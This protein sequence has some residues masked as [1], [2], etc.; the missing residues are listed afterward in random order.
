MEKPEPIILEPALDFFE[1]I[2]YIEEKYKIRV[3]DYLGHMSNEPFLKTK[4]KFN[5]ETWYRASPKDYTPFQKEASVYFNV[6]KQEFDKLEY[7]NYWHWLKDN[8]FDL[9]SNG[10]IEIWGVTNIL[11]YDDTPMWVKEITQ[12]V[13]DEF[14][15]YLDEEGCLNIM[16]KW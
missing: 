15:E 4:E 1:I 12:L 11:E 10:C 13:H 9:I 6:L 8:I 16:I 14:K 5:D 2:K 3:T 7:L